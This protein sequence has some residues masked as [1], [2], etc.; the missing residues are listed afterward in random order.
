MNVRYFHGKKAT[1]AAGKQV[2]MIIVAPG[3]IPSSAT[4][5]L[6]APGNLSMIEIVY[7]L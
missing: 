4:F 1:K 6:P 5:R 7:V 2:V 3:E